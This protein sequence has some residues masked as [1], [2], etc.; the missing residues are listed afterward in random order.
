MIQEFRKVENCH[1]FFPWFL[2]YDRSDLFRKAL[3]YYGK[4]DVPYSDEP[5]R[6]CSR[7]SSEI[8]RPLIIFCRRYNAS[9][10]I[11]GELAAIAWA[12]MDRRH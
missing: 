1:G 7:N 8:G 2:R 3:G 9:A 5:W 11:P 6:I 4:H 10:R 12:P